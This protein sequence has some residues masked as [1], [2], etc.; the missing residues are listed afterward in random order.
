M[1]LLLN[2]LAVSGSGVYAGALLAIGVILGGYWKSLPA[3]EFLEAF[4]TSLPFIGRLVPAVLVPTL[5]GLV[6]SLWFAW[7]E[8]ESR[9]L[10]L[11]ALVST[12]ALLMLTAAWF[13]PTNSQFA[14]GFTRY[15]HDWRVARWS[16]GAVRPDA[17]RITQH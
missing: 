15:P 10:W 14:A 4:R 3:E 5:A 1:R 11:M 17:T 6:G 16:L 8:K 13:G 12:A 7:D 2:V 9:V